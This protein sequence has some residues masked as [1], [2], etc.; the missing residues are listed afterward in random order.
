MRHGIGGEARFADEIQQQNTHF[1][2]G[3]KLVLPCLIAR[4]NA[5]AV[6]VRVCTDEKFRLL[7]PAKPQSLLHR[8]SNLR[9]GI[10]T[11]WKFPVR[12][13]LAR[14]NCDVRNVKSVQ[15]LLHAFQPAATKRRIDKPQTRAIDIRYTLSIYGIDIRIQYAVRD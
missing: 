15:Q 10:R 5:A 13:C 2:S 9:I 3:D 14:H 4:S 11:S 6:A 12:L 1:V 8:L 7:F